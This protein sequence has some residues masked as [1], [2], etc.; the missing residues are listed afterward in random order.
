M[1]EAD[2]VVDIIKN[3]FTYGIRS[4]YIDTTKVARIYENLYSG[5]SVSREFISEIIHNEGIPYGSIFY[6]FSKTSTAQIMQFFNRILQKNTIAYYSL[7]F[8]QHSR[9]FFQF[10]ICSLELLIKFL[11]K[12]NTHNFFSWEFCS[13]N[14]VTTLEAEIANLFFVQDCAITF[15]EICQFFPYVPREK[16]DAELNNSKK[17]LQTIDGRYTLRSKIIFNRNEISEIQKQVSIDIDLIGCAR[18]QNYDFSKNISLN[19]DIPED[20][21]YE[22]IF[23]NFFSNYFVKRGDK[24]YKKLNLS[25]KSAEIPINVFR[26][27][28]FTHEE[29][30]I[31]SLLSFAAK[32]N[33]NNLSALKI[34]YEKMV[35]VN[36]SLLVKN[37]LIE[38]NVAEIDA[39]LQSFVQG[40]IISLKN[41]T[42][43]TGFPTVAGYHWNLFLL[44]SFL[45]LAS[46]KYVLAVPNIN[47][48]NIG[49]IHPISMTFT[50]YSEILATVIIQENVK[51]DK[52]TVE[53][54]VIA[55][56]FRN[57]RGDKITYKIIARAQELLNQKN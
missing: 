7:I 51:M 52:A 19:S 42:S 5:E 26:E 17:Y 44:E 11:K 37:S 1:V 20:A 56:G 29:L 48:S 54:F 23:E 15:D 39:A 50:N 12:I 40:K 36:S 49:A 47:N 43:F 6:F 16:I 22:L 9:F 21:L 35:R 18:L 33:I 45:R 31:Q 30:S 14:K 41:V 2:K 57:K 32:Q 3:N 10:H 8:Q 55:N 53:D 24:I 34:A 13:A 46:K 28:I 25:A 27:F 4:D 38:F